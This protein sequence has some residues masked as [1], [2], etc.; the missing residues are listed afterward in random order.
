MFRSSPNRLAWLALSVVCFVWGTTFLGIRIG[1]HYIPPL[2]FTTTRLVAAGILFLLVYSRRIRWRLI[3]G[4]ILAYHFMLG[5]IIFSIGS[6]LV[7]MA[8]VTISSGLAAVIASMIPV[9]V[10]CLNYL[11]NRDEKPTPMLIAG[12]IIGLTGIF[13]IYGEHAGF[14]LSGHLTAVALMFLAG[15]GWAGGNILLKRRGAVAEPTGAGGFQLLFG[16]L[17]LMPFSYMTENWSS[18]SYGNE[19]VL[20]LT[21][22]IL[23]GSV[24]TYFCYLYALKHL[25]VTV[26]SVYAYVNPVVAMFVGWLLAGETLNL[27]IIIGMAVT[28][29]GVFMVSN[30]IRPAANK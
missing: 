26:V 28:L 3:T 24:L 25:P 27:R 19:V 21:Y 20:V 7:G 29:G 18:V 22:L 17:A 1:V 23:I 10:I 16:G 30:G 8:E 5:A 15:I 13:L 12:I 11:F 6:G 9:W 2:L 4:K 14:S